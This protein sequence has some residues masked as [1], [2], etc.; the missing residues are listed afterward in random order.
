M[1]THNYKM[2]TDAFLRHA[3]RAIK[4]TPEQGRLASTT[5]SG[6]G[7]LKVG[8]EDAKKKSVRRENKS[9]HKSLVAGL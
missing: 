3:L 9:R 8:W 2:R 1:I 4:D 5:M 6:F 7:I